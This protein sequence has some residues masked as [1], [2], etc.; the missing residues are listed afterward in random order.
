MAA[1]PDID[2]Q[3]HG[4][5]QL[6]IEAAEILLRLGI[7]SELTTEALG[8]QRPPFG[9]GGIAAEAPEPRQVLLLALQ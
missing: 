6:G 8:V 3:A 9:E 4:A 7:E 1:A 5:E 2:D